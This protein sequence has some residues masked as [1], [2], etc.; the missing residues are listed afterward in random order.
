MCYHIGWKQARP[1]FRS[2]GGCQVVC[3]QT[4]QQQERPFAAAVLWRHLGKPRTLTPV[5]AA[6]QQIKGA[7]AQSGP[8]SS[9]PRE[10][11]RK[12]SAPVVSLVLNFASH[13]NRCQIR[14]ENAPKP[15]VLA[16]GL[17]RPRVCEPPSLSRA[18]TPCSTRLPTLSTVEN[19]RTEHL[20]TLGCITRHLRPP[21]WCMCHGP[22][23]A[24]ALVL[25]QENL[26][27]SAH[28]W[29]C[30]QVLWLS[31]GRGWST[32]IWWGQA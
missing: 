11:N 27:P 10:V 8:G 1:P 12:W 17:L 30:L 7:N 25:S 3:P 13:A 22:P 21:V 4:S 14:G 26:P 2:V 5:A 32:G 20:E 28:N 19:I 16:L 31:R 24:R 15:G 18:A 9:A 23:A 29:P 6:C